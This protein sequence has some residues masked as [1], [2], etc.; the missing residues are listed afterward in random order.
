MR[1]NPF[2]ITSDVPDEWT[3]PYTGQ[4]MKPDEPQKPDKLQ[5]KKNGFF[6]YRNI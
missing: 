3:N 2:R 6:S 1:K 4:V 5:N